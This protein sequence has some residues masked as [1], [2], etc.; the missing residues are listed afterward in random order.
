MLVTNLPA[1]IGRLTFSCDVDSVA[2]NPRQAGG[3]HSAH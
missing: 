3:M 2:L 1:D